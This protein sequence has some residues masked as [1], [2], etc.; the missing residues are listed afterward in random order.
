[1]NDMLRRTAALEKTLAKFK[2]KPLDFVRADCARMLRFH[3]LSMGH[4][5]PA[6][7]SYRS[8]I[9][10]IRALRQLGGLPAVLD[11]FLPRIP[12]ARM[13]PGDV[14]VMPGE[15]GVDAGVVCLGF[16]VAGWFEGVDEMV[17]IV[18]NDIVAAWRA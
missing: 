10:A 8:S 17:N 9:G 14:A 2:G 4:R 12:Y 7:P 1:M 11:S 6:L 13:L 16:K 15:D 5:P 18:P 3:L